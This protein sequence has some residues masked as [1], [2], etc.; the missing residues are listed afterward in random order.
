VVGAVPAAQPAGAPVHAIA[1][2]TPGAALAAEVQERAFWR[3]FHPANAGMAW[4]AE[5][6][7]AIGWRHGLEQRG[8]KLSGSLVTGPRSRIFKAGAVG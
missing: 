8:D 2:G 4:L 6:R 3:I 1:E 7:L 5:A